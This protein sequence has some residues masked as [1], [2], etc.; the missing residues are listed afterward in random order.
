MDSQEK[1]P[2]RIQAADI[3]RKTA[4]QELEGK[5]NPLKTYK[6]D[7]TA[8][9]ATHPNALSNGDELGKGDVNGS[10][11]SKTDNEVRIKSSLLNMYKEGNEYK[12]PE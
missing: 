5:L 11:G 12:S 10:I 4:K 1:T 6:D 7:A 2:V 9:G 8:Y 3:L